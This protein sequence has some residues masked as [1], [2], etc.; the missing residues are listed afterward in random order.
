MTNGHSSERGGR[1]NADQ[2][3]S[4]TASSC[5]AAT[6][7]YIGQNGRFAERRTAPSPDR[8]TTMLRCEGPK[9]VDSEGKEVIL[10]GVSRLVRG[11]G[12]GLM[13]NRPASAAISCRRTSPM[14]IRVMR[15]PTGRR[16]SPPSDRRNTTSS[17]PSSTNTVRPDHEFLPPLDWLMV[18]PQSTPTPMP[19]G[20][21]RLG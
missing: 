10:R 19:S 18:V 3:L 20:S 4:F 6:D 2:H 7:R 16:C 17:G 15:K 5:P 1:R 9:I 13:A 14:A 12:L 11:E 21:P 8:T